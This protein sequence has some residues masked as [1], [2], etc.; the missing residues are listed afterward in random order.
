MLKWASELLEKN[1]LSKSILSHVGV[2]T[3]RFWIGNRIYCI[4]TQLVTLSNC[5]AITNSHNVQFT[6][7]RIKSSQSAVSTPVVAWWRLLFCLPSY[8]LATVPQLII[9]P[10]SAWA[11]QKTS[12]LCCRIHCCVRV[13]WDAHVIVTHPSPSN[14]RCLQSHY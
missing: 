1:V 3:D 7:A 6:T 9:A 11:A 5:S 2:T 4:L 10:I 8:R 12:M 13:C 14:G